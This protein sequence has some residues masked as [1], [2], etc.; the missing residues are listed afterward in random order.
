VDYLNGDCTK[1]NLNELT[2]DTRY[3]QLSMPI[4]EY[5]SQ[6]YSSVAETINESIISYNYFSPKIAEVKEKT[7]VFFWSRPTISWHLSCESK[8]LTRSSASTILTKAE[9]LNDD[10]AMANWQSEAC[11][12]IALIFPIGLMIAL[13]ASASLF[14]RKDV[15]L[16]VKIQLANV[17]IQLCAAVCLLIFSAGALSTFTDKKD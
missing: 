14:G 6:Y 8:N 5:D 1:S 7:Q 17:S 2:Y 11:F 3:T 15:N 16:H 12:Y 13:L 4:N 10:V 9:T